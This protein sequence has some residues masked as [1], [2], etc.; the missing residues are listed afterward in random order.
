MNLRRPI[1]LDGIG[2]DRRDLVTCELVDVTTR[3]RC[4]AIGSG[5]AGERVDGDGVGAGRDHASVVGGCCALEA[6]QGFPAGLT[7]RVGALEDHVTD[8][9][10]AH[11]FG[12]VWQRLIKPVLGERAADDTGIE[13]HVPTVA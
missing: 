4:H 8:D 3:D 10:P 6:L 7:D 1:D 11:I 12:E 5:I 9:G 2:G 13:C